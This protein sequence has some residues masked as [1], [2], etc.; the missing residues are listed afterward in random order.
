MKPHTSH[1]RLVDSELAAGLGNLAEQVAGMREYTAQAAQRRNHVDAMMLAQL[2]QHQ[3]RIDALEGPGLAYLAEQV[4]GHSVA[5]AGVGL[6]PLDGAGA[7]AASYTSAPGEPWTHAYNEAHASFISAALDDPVLQRRIREDAALPD[8]FGRGF[9]ERVVE[10]PWLASQA[11]RGRLLDAGSTLNH[12]HV[13]ARLRP[14]VDDLHIV[15]L[16]PEE[17]SYPQMGVSYLYADL[18]DLPMRDGTYD[19]VTS[20]STLEHVGLDNRY[21]GSETRPDDDPQGESVRAARELRRVVRPGGELY[22]TVPVGR[23]ERYDWVRS[24][25]LA[26]LEELAAAFEP[27]DCMLTFFRYHGQQGWIRATADEVADAHYRDH[28][29]AEARPDEHLVAAEAVACLSV[30]TG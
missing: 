8:A 14:R 2:R 25:T 28:F 18:R 30:T 29:T 16:A 19:R 6:T 11:L 15:T 12:L 20:I 23:G 10:F 1:Q 27:A 4:R 9:D 17:R 5:L 21:Y 26:E 22:I 13:L 7:V 24:F 3:R